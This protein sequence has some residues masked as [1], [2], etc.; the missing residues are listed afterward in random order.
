MIR[1]GLGWNENG[2]D[3]SQ[4]DAKH[5]RNSLLSEIG[6]N[7]PLYA[8]L[9][10]TI[11]LKRERVCETFHIL[12]EFSFRN[13]GCGAAVPATLPPVRK[14]WRAPTRNGQSLTVGRPSWRWAESTIPTYRSRAVSVVGVHRFPQLAPTGPT[15]PVS[16]CPLRGVERKWRF[17]AVRTGFDPDRTSRLLWFR[18]INRTCCLL[19]RNGHADWVER[20]PVWTVNRKT[21]ARGEY[22][23][24][25]RVGPGNFT[26]SLSQ[27]RT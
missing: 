20:C 23:A 5:F 26:P 18:C 3:D 13:I 11:Q 9:E 12:R 4:D 24:F 15:G 21:S 14:H 25:C 17:G 22:F 6:S 7:R 27:I 10:H 8:D 16:R 19:A 1:E 2:S